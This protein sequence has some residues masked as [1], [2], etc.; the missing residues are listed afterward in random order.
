MQGKPV[1]DLVQGSVWWL[2]SIS[3][4]MFSLQRYLASFYMCIHHVPFGSWNQGKPCCL[5]SEGCII[6]IIIVIIIIVI[7]IIVIIIIAHLH[8]ALHNV[9]QNLDSSQRVVPARIR[10][11]Q[12]QHHTELLF[13]IYHIMLS[14]AWFVSLSAWLA[15]DIAVFAEPSPQ[16]DSRLEVYGHQIFCVVHKS[17]LV[18]VNLILLQYQ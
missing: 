8:K 5:N 15:K 9:H 4:S 7:I 10:P 17:R 13:E 3:Y 14:S 18:S 12:Y 2:D 11:F 1:W 6:V 16:T